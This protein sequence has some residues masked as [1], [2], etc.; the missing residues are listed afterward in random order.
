MS[1]TINKNNFESEVVKCEKTV[2]LDFWTTWCG[3]CKMIAP[4]IDEIA[5]ENPEIVVGKVNVDEEQELAQ[6]FGIMSVPTLV[7]VK[8]G[9]I[10]NQSS[11]VRPKS[12]IIEMFED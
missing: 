6:A 4:I 9:K 3:P 1:V 11:G 12:K 8:N 10:V 7:V 2:L 5:Q